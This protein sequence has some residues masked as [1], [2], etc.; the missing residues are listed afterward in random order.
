V[1]AAHARQAFFEWLPIA[2]GEVFR[3]FSFGPLLDL[4]VLDMRTYKD[5]TTPTCTPT[6]H[7]ACSEWPSGSG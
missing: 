4:F 3:R 2:S 6:R 1:L 7:G 5:P